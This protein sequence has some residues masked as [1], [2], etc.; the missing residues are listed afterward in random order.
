[1]SFTREHG[2][3]T[4]ACDGV[5][6][7]IVVKWD[8]ALRLMALVHVLV[9]Q[10]RLLRGEPPELRIV[11]DRTRIFTLTGGLRSAPIEC[12][13][14]AETA[15]VTC[16]PVA[17]GAADQFELVLKEDAATELVVALA[18]RMARNGTTTLQGRGATKH[19]E[20]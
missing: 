8:V 2:V 18:E 5:N 12:T 9:L 1:M 11:P 3:F 7:G 4:T 15:D 14:N 10:N 20:E 16:G 6:C 19:G 13:W 17:A